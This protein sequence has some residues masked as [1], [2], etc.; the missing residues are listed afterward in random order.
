MEADGIILGWRALSL[1]V[2]DRL[3]RPIGLSKVRHKVESSGIRIGR[4]MNGMLLF[5]ASD[6]EATVRLF[7]GERG[8][9]A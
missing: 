4:K 2:G 1:E 6:V 3:G 7:E 5:D 9:V 8:V